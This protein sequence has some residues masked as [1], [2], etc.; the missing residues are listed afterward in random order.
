MYEQDD[1]QDFAA[2]IVWSSVAHLADAERIAETLVIEKLAGCVHIL[3]AGRSFYLWQEELHHDAE[4]L[5]MIKTSRA[6]YATLEKR[7]VALH[8]YDTPEILAVPVASG[9]PAYLSWLQQTTRTAEQK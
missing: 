5:L 3:P 8:P 2:L 7:V 6:L 1:E 4:Y 9:L